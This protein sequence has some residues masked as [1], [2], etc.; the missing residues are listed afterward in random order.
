M[1]IRLRGTIGIVGLIYLIIGIVIAWQYD[2]L[3]PGL[4]RLLLSCLLAIFLWPLV[5][6]G[7]GLHLR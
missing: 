4:L 1:A 5:L 3:T 6:L 7:V 2:Y